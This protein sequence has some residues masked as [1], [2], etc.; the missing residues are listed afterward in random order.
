M[1]TNVS[2]LDNL[3]GGLKGLSL[4]NKTKQN[5]NKKTTKNKTKTN[6]QNKQA[7]TKKK[8]Y[9][10]CKH[11]GTPLDERNCS[12]NGSL[13]IGLGILRR[14]SPCNGGTCQPEETQQLW[15][16]MEWT[17]LTQRNGLEASSLAKTDSA[18]EAL[19]KI[20]ELF[21]ITVENQTNTLDDLLA[22]RDLWRTLS[23]G[24]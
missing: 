2:L 5:K 4:K 22:K 19:K 9:L 6:K 7:K 24:R 20:R 17:Q 23:V 21:A 10:T 1:M 13:V 12:A 11:C 14:S 15:K 18:V 8:A 16:V 3:K